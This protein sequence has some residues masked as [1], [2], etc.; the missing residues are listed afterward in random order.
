MTTD[1]D[2]LISHKA[3]AEQCYRLLIADTEIKRN[4]LYPELQKMHELFQALTKRAERLEREK[5]QFS[6]QLNELSRSLDLATRVDPMTGL[7]NRRAV[8][9]MLEQEFSRA[10]RH[11]RCISIVMAD[12]DHFRQLNEIYGFNLCDDVLVEV[13]RVLRGCLRNEDICARWG[14]EE[15]L[16]LLPE[17]RLSGALAV[18][19]KI[20]ESVAM[21]EFKANKP[22]IQLTISLGVCEYHPDQ[23]IFEAITRADHAL[24]QAKVGGRNRAVTAP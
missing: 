6:T 2:F 24:Y 1:R 12:L 16:L 18:A 15:F 21:T 20:R 10:N 23:N 3:S 13:A 7:L 14:G 5:R 9:E 4:H 17:T 19:N 11:Q 22:G 8:M